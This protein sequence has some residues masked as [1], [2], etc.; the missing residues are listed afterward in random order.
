MLFTYS[1]WYFH[2]LAFACLHGCFAKLDVIFS[3]KP[4][5]KTS[6]FFP[7]LS[8]RFLLFDQALFVFLKYIDA[9][10]C[11]SIW[12]LK[13]I[14]WQIH[15]EGNWSGDFPGALWPG[16]FT[17]RMFP[18]T[19]DSSNLL[20]Y[21]CF[22]ANFWQSLWKS[23]SMRVHSYYDCRFPAWAPSRVFLHICWSVYVILNIPV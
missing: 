9:V 8:K 7:S 4:G 23:T 6:W 19:K 3:S 16:E 12:Y 5:S 13:K 22:N 18:T 20:K 21:H 2:I 15:Q 17:T 14:S 11:Y 10:N 1:K